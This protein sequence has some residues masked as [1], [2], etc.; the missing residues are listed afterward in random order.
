MTSLEDRVAG[1]V[2]GGAAGDALGA[3]YEFT[4]P[5]PDAPIEMRGGGPFGFAP[6]EWTDDTAQAAAVLG[7]LATGSTDVLAIGQ[8]FLDWIAGGPKDVGASTG[9]VLRHAVTADHL[10]SSAA[11]YFAHNPRG[12]A[13][14]GS[15]MRTSPVPLH[16]LGDDAAI[17]D[18]ATRVSLLTHG[19]PLAAE[20]C[21]IWSLAIDRAVRLEVFDIRAGLPRLPSDRA[22][23]WTDRID[24]AEANPPS[25]FGTGNGFVVTALQAAWSAIVHTPI[26]EDRPERHLPLALRAAV[27]IGHDTDTVAAI[28]GQL[29]G[30]RWGASAVPEAWRRMLHGWGADGAD[31]L[32]RM[33]VRAAG[34]RAAEGRHEIVTET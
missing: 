6:G 2:V 18:L 12:A 21:V 15:L 1:A 26:P 32:A 29:L 7:V 3:G 17:A 9:A 33:T 24:E 16:A 30:A 25:R 22:A 23:W 8:R 4:V 11:T 27:R 19:D 20:G 10:T 34:H 14:N 13:G 5:A 28:A 31:D